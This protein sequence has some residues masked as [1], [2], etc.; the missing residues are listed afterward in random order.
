MVDMITTTQPFVFGKPAIGKGIQFATGQETTG[1]TVLFRNG[2]QV[3]G[4]SGAQ[5]FF[6]GKSTAPFQGNIRD[7]KTGDIV[8]VNSA[9]GQA[10]LAAHKAKQTSAQAALEAGN[11]LTAAA[12]GET[13]KAEALL[14]KSTPAVKTIVASSTKASKVVGGAVGFDSPTSFR[15]GSLIGGIVEPYKQYSSLSPTADLAI[16]KPKP[17]IK[18]RSPTVAEGK[19][20]QAEGEALQKQA[21]KDSLISGGGGPSPTTVRKITAFNAKLDLYNRRVEMAQGIQDKAGVSYLG[22][23]VWKPSK[24]QQYVDIAGKQ[25]AVIPGVGIR[26]FG[27]EVSSLG[28]D[29][30]GLEPFDIPEEVL[31][32]SRAEQLAIGAAVAGGVIFPGIGLATGV[33]LAVIGGELIGGGFGAAGFSAAAEPFI[34]KMKPGVVTEFS[35]TVPPPSFDIPATMLP[36]KESLLRLDIFPK[37]TTRTQTPLELET[38]KGWARIGVSTLGFAVGG[39]IG[40]GVVGS[41]QKSLASNIRATITTNTEIGP[42]GTTNQ[43]KVNGKTTKINLV[44]PEGTKILKNGKIVTVTKKGIVF[45][46]GDTAGI[47]RT[48]TT[49]LITAERGLVPSGFGLTT[50]PPKLPVGLPITSFGLTDF[51]PGVLGLLPKRTQIIVTQR[52]KDIFG[53][54]KGLFEEIATE[55]KQKAI[56]RREAKVTAKEFRRKQ[57]EELKLKF[58]TVPKKPSVAAKKAE[59]FTG[60]ELEAKTRAEARG[61]VDFQKVL[62]LPTPLRNIYKVRTKGLFSDIA[63]EQKMRAAQR[64]EITS[65][66]ETLPFVKKPSVAARKAETFAQ[67][68]AERGFLADLRPTKEQIKLRRKEAFEEAFAKL[69]TFPKRKPGY[70]ARR[71]ALFKQIEAERGFAAELRPKFKPKTGRTKT[72]EELERDVLQ[73]RRRGLKRPARPR[74]RKFSPTRRFIQMLPVESFTG[75]GTVQVQRPFVTP[76]S[77]AGLARGLSRVARTPTEYLFEREMGMVYSKPIKPVAGIFGKIPETGFKTPQPTIFEKELMRDVSKETGGQRFASALGFS[78]FQRGKARAGI[79][80]PVSPRER[81]SP[82]DQV[83]ILPK[84]GVIDLAKTFETPTIKFGTSVAEISKVKPREKTIEQLLPRQI[85][86]GRIKDLTKTWERVTEIEKE[87]VKPLPK[88]PPLILPTLKKQPK[89]TGIGGYQVQV[90]GKGRKTRSGWQP[91]KFKPAVKGVLPRKQALALGQSKVAGTAPRTFKLV[92]TIG[93][94]AQIGKIP[95]FRPEMFYKKGRTYI[96]KTRFAIDQPGERKAITEKG[97]STLK[98][99]RLT[100]FKPFRKKPK[101]TKKKKTRRR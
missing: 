83:E 66:F 44:V 14:E 57:I 51:S 23:D 22:P 86:R 37:K 72:L 10:L 61:P 54:S 15:G 50:T 63:I 26:D 76:G 5:S 30:R 2:Q 13:K 71:A 49:P 31:E 40:A 45:K 84:E 70:A 35:K 93:K 38:T 32:R 87:K 39:S 41:I 58:G 47:V 80:Q 24:P 75:A 1:A 53:R 16:G 88:T 20:L 77:Y 100:G 95:K 62:G 29:V 96:E 28:F 42:V 78:V 8:S 33:P 73:W 6:S 3:G 69:G 9:R 101:K 55:Q 7:I 48:T 4:A 74:R 60:L 91:G 18:F 90:R 36:P 19:T 79:R 43:V 17:A 56:A 21:V 52:P 65:G 12:R 89:P 92:P 67:I 82:L 98:G 59:F 46:P 34:S 85:P 99:L 68:K 81:I 64:K 25:V 94:P 11:I 27:G 97:I